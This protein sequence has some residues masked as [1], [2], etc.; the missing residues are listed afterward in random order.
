[1]YSIPLSVYTY[2]DTWHTVQ[3]N[4]NLLMF[5]GQDEKMSKRKNHLNRKFRTISSGGSLERI[6]TL[7]SVNP[8]QTR[9]PD[10]TPQKWQLKK[11]QFA[12]RN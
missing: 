10:A 9:A 2:P 6:L 3:C 5:L 8:S 4:W 12:K 7:G 11:N 1:M